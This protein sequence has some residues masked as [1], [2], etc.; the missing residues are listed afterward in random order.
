MKEES[1]S[2]L[3]RLQYF[4]DNQKGYLLGGGLSQEP[5]YKVVEISEGKSDVIYQ[6]QTK[7]WNRFER[8]VYLLTGECIGDYHPSASHTDHSGFYLLFAFCGLAKVTGDG[9]GY[10]FLIPSREMKSIRENEKDGFGFLDHFSAFRIQNEQILFHH[11]HLG[12]RV[13]DLTTRKLH[14]LRAMS[15]T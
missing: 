6:N 1:I 11:T 15:L 2:D 4:A 13:F 3:A 14:R 10:E 8:A 9:Q 12:I 7:I 5:E